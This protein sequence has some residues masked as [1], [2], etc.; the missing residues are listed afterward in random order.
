[1]IELAADAHKRRRCGV[2]LGD[3]SLFKLVQASQL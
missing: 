3:P 1:M 2:F